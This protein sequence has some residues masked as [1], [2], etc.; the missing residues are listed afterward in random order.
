MD[1]KGFLQDSNGNNS[2][3]RLSGYILILS[4]LVMKFTL[5]Q[6]GLTNKFAN[7]I[8]EL[9]GIASGLIYAGVGLLSVG[10]VEYF[11]PKNKDDV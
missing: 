3:K 1:T 4:G 8:Y 10:V 5:F 6:W 7:P 11:K 2:S 9:D